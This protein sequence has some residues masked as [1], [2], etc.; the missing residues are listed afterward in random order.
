MTSPSSGD[1]ADND[2]DHRGPPRPPG[3]PQFLP[4]LPITPNQPLLTP[5][6]AQPHVGLPVAPTPHAT[7]Q[8]QSGHD[9]FD[10]AQSR[11][12]LGDVAVSLAI[13]F[14]VGIALYLANKAL[15]G[16]G[17]PTGAWLPLMFTGPPAVQ[18]AHLVWVSHRKGRGLGDFDFRFTAEDIGLGFALFVGGLVGAGLAGLG[19]VRLT[20]NEPTAA[21]ADA[22]LDSGGDGI[23]IWLVLFAFLGATLIPVVEELLYR[24]L[25]WNA[26]EKRG[27]SP[28]HVYLLTSVIFAA[29]HMEL[30]RTPV[31]L[32]LAL[33]LGFGRLKTGRLGP[34]VATH[35]M[36]NTVGMLATLA[37]VAT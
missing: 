28:T 17:I 19:T 8:P 31:L 16:E 32:V 34:S 5:P 15:G 12:G 13:F 24:G 21:A 29:I 37:Q 20:G 14:G 33:V 11:W 18:L 6:P 27:M 4:P 3:A 7:A 1:P 30:E 23:T 2:H 22:L 35:V 26:L 9:R 36:I 25:F 10:H